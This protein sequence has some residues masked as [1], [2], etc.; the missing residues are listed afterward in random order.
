VIRP[1]APD[2]E[3]DS[4]LM[5]DSMSWR[6]PAFDDADP[7][8]TV[9]L[10]PLA[11]AGPAA[12]APDQALG[13]TAAILTRLEKRWHNAFNQVTVHMAYDLFACADYNLVPKGAELAEAMIEIH[14][15]GCAEPQCVLLKPPGVLLLRNSEHESKI[16][17]FLVARGFVSLA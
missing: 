1:H 17:A 3:K 10:A 4:T 13:I 14:V 7:P 11:C 16:I 9:T 12:L 8:R 2:S 5:S 15:A 6:R